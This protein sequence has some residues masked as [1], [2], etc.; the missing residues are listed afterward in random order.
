MTKTQPPSGILNFQA[1]DRVVYGQ[2]SGEA[3]AALARD[4]GAQRVF[5]VTSRSGEQG[6]ITRDIQTALGQRFAGAYHGCQP[7]SPRECVMEGAQ[8]AAGA[9]LLV[10]LG[11][12]S[13]IDAAKVMQLALWQGLD[14]TDALERYHSGQITDPNSVLPANGKAPIRCVAVPTTL[15]GAEFTSFAGVTETASG[16]KQVFAHPLFVPR[17]VVYDPGAAVSTPAW[18]LLST[19]IRAVDHCVETF[20][21]SGATPYSDAAAAHGLRLLY[22]GLPR[23]KNSPNDLA[24]LL[25]CQ[26]AAW[27]AISGPAAGVPVGISHAIGR[28]LGGAFGVP[29]GR[30]SCLLLPAAL[31][32]NA[33]DPICAERQQ[34]LLQAA[35]LPGDCLA[36]TIESLIRELSE[37]TRLSEVGIGRDQF[38]RLA[39]LAL[40]MVGQPSTAGNP[41]PVN[42]AEDIEAVL[43]YAAAGS[44][45]PD[46]SGLSQ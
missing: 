37:P 30:T 21:S 32:W 24:N 45:E 6:A 43:E 34:N 25:E 41:R 46:R 5:L 4:Y 33:E 44:A 23:L 13:A 20:C 1:Q 29:H 2:P 42:R 35:S 40:G 3:V 16:S 39:E 19:G 7:H 31:R 12:G 36:D 22:R 15:S 18:V 27:L 10:A 8:A 28:V 26:L 14:N 9:D 11:G 17:A 38:Q